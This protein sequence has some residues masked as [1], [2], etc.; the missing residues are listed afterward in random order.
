VNETSR[1]TF[2][3][4]RE[5]AAANE[6]CTQPLKVEG[7]QREMHKGSCWL[8]CVPAEL[9]EELFRQQLTR[10]LAAFGAPTLAQGTQVALQAR[11][12]PLQWG[13]RSA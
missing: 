7:N 9:V 1:A 13:S 3:G 5:Q 11:F 4:L 12:Q 10:L 8:M 6:P 2:W